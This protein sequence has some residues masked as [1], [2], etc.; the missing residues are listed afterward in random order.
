MKRE[1]WIKFLILFAFYGCISIENK[2]N[3]EKDANQEICPQNAKRYE[4]TCI[5]NEGYEDC[6]FDWE[7]GCETNKMSDPDN[8]GGCGISCGKNSVCVKGV[9]GCN[10]GYQNTNGLWSD[11]CETKVEIR[12]IGYDV[13]TDDGA[14]E[15]FDN[16]SDN[17]KPDKICRNGICVSYGYCNTNSD[18]P[19]GW[20]C[21]VL[22]S[23][24]EECATDDDCKNRT[25]G[26]TKCD[27]GKTFVCIEPPVCNPP[28]DPNCQVC[29]DGNC[30]LAPNKCCQNSDCP[31]N[32]C[33]NYVCIENQCS[34]LCSTDEECK[35]W[36]NDSYFICVNNQCIT[37]DCKDDNE[38]DQHCGFV[39]CGLCSNGR[40]QCKPECISGSGKMCDPCDSDSDCDT[41][42]GFTCYEFA[43]P[44][45]QSKWKACTHPCSK[46]DDCEDPSFDTP[47]FI[48][49]LIGGGEG[50]CC[51]NKGTLCSCTQ[52][53]VGP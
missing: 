38:C 1:Y 33:I 30:V 41:I 50:R 52:G 24:C 32:K 44:L 18:C 39:N 27:I 3:L 23:R 15:C 46:S 34:D 37:A 17:C 45:N 7:N 53:G 28:C 13:S 11:G 19:C 8:C 2:S 10:E 16:C 36:C 43:N 40:C 20:Y 29:K 21:N 12:D 51:A 14:L 6:D 47:S 26:R 9:C 25:N 22:E 31:S 35:L 5:C 49:S 42:K 48:C 4:D